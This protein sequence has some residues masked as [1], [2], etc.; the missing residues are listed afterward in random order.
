MQSSTDLDAD[1]DAKGDEFTL[2][3]YADNL[4]EYAGA[5][6]PPPPPPVTWSY[7]SEWLWDKLGELRCTRWHEDDGNY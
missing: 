6:P 4:S 3:D 2:D 7:G 1:S 5:P